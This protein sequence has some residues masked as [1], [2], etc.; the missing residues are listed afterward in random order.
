MKTIIRFS[1][2][3]FLILASAC[4]APTSPDGDE[5]EE[6]AVVRPPGPAG[7]TYYVRPDGGTYAECTGLADAPYPGS[8]AGQPCAWNHP[9]QA[10]PPGGEPRI[11]GGDTLIIGAGSYMMGYSAP[12]AENCDYE[13]SY[14]CIISAVPSGPDAAHP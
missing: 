3:A 1:L 9:F 2:T 6:P 7:S 5:T 4:S 13:G 10:L 11:L 8:G 12:G 14:D